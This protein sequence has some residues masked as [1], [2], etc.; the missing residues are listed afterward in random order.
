ML[1]YELR[2]HHSPLMTLTTFE[3]LVCRPVVASLVFG[4]EN[5]K[6]RRDVLR[7]PSA[8][9]KTCRLV[10]DYA[11]M[12]LVILATVGTLRL[13]PCYHPNPQKP[14]GRKQNSSLGTI[15]DLH[16]AQ[17]LPSRISASLEPGLSCFQIP[18]Y[19][20]LGSGAGKKSIEC[21]CAKARCNYVRP[22]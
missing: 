19:L 5:I 6:S 20:A 14:Q 8:R 3:C 22:G 4:K 16:R 9:Q 18:M 1:L 12:L 10:Y 13:R 17:H 11:G 21:Q 15:A 7:L 2:R